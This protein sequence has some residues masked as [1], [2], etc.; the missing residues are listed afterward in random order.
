MLYEFITFNR[1]EI[2]NRC[3]AKVAARTIPPPSEEEISH[4]VPLFLDQLVDCCSPEVTR[5]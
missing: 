5:P 1:D 2:I 3:R 4:G